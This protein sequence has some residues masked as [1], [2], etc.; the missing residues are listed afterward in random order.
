MDDCYYIIK[1]I[2]PDRQYENNPRIW[3]DMPDS[4]RD[5]GVI[6]IGLAESLPGCL[7]LACPEQNIERAEQILRT[8]PFLQP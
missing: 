6:V 1:P 5:L 7:Y 8:L 4:L 3:P 2:V